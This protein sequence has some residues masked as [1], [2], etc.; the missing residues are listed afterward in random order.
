MNYKSITPILTSSFIIFSISLIINVSDIW[1]F[2]EKQNSNIN[3]QISLIAFEIGKYL[4]QTATILQ[5]DNANISKALSSLN[6]AQVRLA[7]LENWHANSTIAQMINELGTASAQLKGSTSGSGGFGGASGASSSS[8]STIAPP[9]A[10]GGFIGDQSGAVSPGSFEGSA[11]GVL[12]SASSTAAGST[13]ST[14][15]GSTSGASG[16][17]TGTA[18]LNTRTT[19][20]SESGSGT[21][22]T[23][24]ETTEGSE[25]V[26]TSPS[27]SGSFAD[28][29]NPGAFSSFQDPIPRQP[30]Q[31]LHPT[32]PQTPNLPPEP[33]E[34]LAPVIPPPPSN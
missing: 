32:L 18:S 30:G 19:G 28:L 10:S 2:H 9:P 5:S 11:D 6:L 21:D 17:G 14:D 15:S 8:S 24:T 23:N 34:P 3:S 16:F 27:S 26:A 25:S 12:P 29:S 20:A 33:R 7:Q 31:P 4:N 1:G 22:S 13:I